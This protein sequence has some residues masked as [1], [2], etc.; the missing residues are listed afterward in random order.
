MS[1]SQGVIIGGAV[2]G[3]ILLVSGIALFFFLKRR[4][5]A[6]LSETIAPY[7]ESTSF[8]VTTLGLRNFIGRHK[9]YS[10]NSITSVANQPVEAGLMSLEVNGRT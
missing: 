8:G 1:R 5:R 10:S 6:Q 3:A 9:H 4:R 2:S 7:V